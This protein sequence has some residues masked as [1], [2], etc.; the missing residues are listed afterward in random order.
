MRDRRR[1]QA[2][3]GLAG[4]AAVVI[5][6]GSSLLMPRL[7]S[8]TGRHPRGHVASPVAW[9]A[10]AAAPP[11]SAAPSG[12]ASAPAGSWWTPLPTAA[13]SFVPQELVIEKLRVRAPT[14][15]KGVDSHN[16]MQAPDGPWDVAWYPFTSR[17]G[18][19]SNA[20]FSGHRDFARVGPA[21]FWRLDQLMSGDEIDIVSSQRTEI[22]YGV[23]QVWSYSDS[24]IP[25]SQ[26]LASD[27]VDEITLITCSGRYTPATGYDHR[28]VVRAVRA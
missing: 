21:V 13:A 15:I 18:S 11:A 6:A 27:R 4:A 14:E 10:K 12:G 24:D 2:V 1:R 5:V 28:L 23:S 26:V 25:M 7:L 8:T 17:P 22:R 9:A 19:G 16:Q 20:V 3:L